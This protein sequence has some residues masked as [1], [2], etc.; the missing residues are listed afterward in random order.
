MAILCSYFDTTS[1]YFI[2]FHAMLHGDPGMLPQAA[3][4]RSF[5]FGH[6]MQ[7]TVPR[8]GVLGWSAVDSLASIPAMFDAVVNFQWSQVCATPPTSWFLRVFNKM[9]SQG[10]SWNSEELHRNYTMIITYVWWI[11]QHMLKPAGCVFEYAPMLL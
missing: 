8:L 4:I 3:E 2:D 11:C 6:Q 9:R 5:C 7:I 10:R 1:G